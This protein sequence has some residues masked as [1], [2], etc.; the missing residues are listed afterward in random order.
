MREE[1]S[2]VLLI[3]SAKSRVARGVSHHPAFMSSCLTII[4][5]FL[6]CV[7]DRGVSPCVPGVIEEG[8]DAC[9]A[10]NVGYT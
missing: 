1:E 7:P 6:P 3:A 8:E 4:H 5:M 9:G 10:V 2:L